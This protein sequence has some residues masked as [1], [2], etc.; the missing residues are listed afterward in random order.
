MV[1]LGVGGARE[2]SS[3]KSERVEISEA[4]DAQQE[5]L[6]DEPEITDNV[7]Y[8]INVEQYPYCLSSPVFLAC[9]TLVP[10]HSVSEMALIA[11]SIGRKIT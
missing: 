5:P 4:G 8:C 1:E 11:R 9:S 3:V 10:K 7:A 6:S 2:M